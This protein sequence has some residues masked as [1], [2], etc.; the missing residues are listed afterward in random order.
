MIPTP[1]RNL[2]IT[3]DGLVNE[4]FWQWMVTLSRV[5]LIVGAGSPE[6]IVAARPTELYMDSAGVAGAILYIKRDADVGGDKSLGWIL[7]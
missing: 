3:N 7:V 1:P 6:G 5:P 2:P 4:V